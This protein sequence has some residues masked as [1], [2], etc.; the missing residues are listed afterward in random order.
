MT[1]LRTIPLN[2]DSTPYTNALGQTA[3]AWGDA[4]CLQVSRG[5][6]AGVITQ[7]IVPN[8]PDSGISGYADWVTDPLGVHQIV[9]KTSTD[10]Y[11]S[12]SLSPRT[13]LTTPPEIVAPGAPYEIW[14]AWESMFPEAPVFPTAGKITFMQVHDSP[15]VGN[16]NPR[17]MPLILLAGD[18]EIQTWLPAAALPIESGSYNVVSLCQLVRNK[19]IK[20]A[21]RIKLSEE[22]N[23]FIEI[24]IDGVSS[25]KRYNIGTAYNDTFGPYFKLGIYNMS[26]TSGINP[27]ASI[28]HANARHYSSPES[29]STVMGGI[30]TKSKTA[31]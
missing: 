2:G 6:D 18:G 29:Y 12:G 20:F 31:W 28:Y 27:I 8:I 21:I 15:N 13:E 7:Y 22:S 1:L 25:Y 4:N 14:Y 24:F 3:A 23:G 17:W 11:V 5:V 26:H 16:V 30:I 19:W 10:A 9:L